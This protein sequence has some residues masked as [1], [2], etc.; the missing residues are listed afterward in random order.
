MTFPY[1]GNTHEE[2]TG[3]RGW[4]APIAQSDYVIKTG[5]GLSDHTFAFLGI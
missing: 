1:K 5:V 2:G 4:P 3:E